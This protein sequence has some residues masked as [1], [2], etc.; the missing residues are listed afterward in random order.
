MAKVADIE[1]VV[2]TL[3]ETTLTPFP[4]VGVAPV[5]K[6]VPVIVTR[7]F[8]P[9]T[10][11]RGLIDVMVGAGEDWILK[12]WLALPPPGAPFVTVT[13]TDSAVVSNAAGTLTTSWVAFCDWTVTAVAPN[14]TVDVAMK[15][16]PVIVSVVVGA[17][18]TTLDGDSDVMVGGLLG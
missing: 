7:T 13:V 1:V 12:S 9:R 8:V 17:P 14:V 2:S 6:L 11:D 4:M 5:M 18:A 15:F 10:P 16:V 3:N